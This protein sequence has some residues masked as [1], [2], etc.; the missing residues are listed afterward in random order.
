MATER[1]PKTV[2]FL[3]HSFNRN[4]EKRA[5]AIRGCAHGSEMWVFLAGCERGDWGDAR[6]TCFSRAPL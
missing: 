6:T 5:T 3:S 4:K 2:R 1:N